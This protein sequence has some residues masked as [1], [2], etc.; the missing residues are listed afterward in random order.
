MTMTRRLGLFVLTLCLVAASAQAQRARVTGTVVD[1]DGRPARRATVL[2]VDQTAI[3]GRAV[4]DSQGR[5][6]VADLAAGRYELRA[7]MEGFA[8]PPVT[9]ALSPDDSQTVTLALQV[10]AVSESVVVTAAGRELP[11]SRVTDS[12][13][14][15]TADDIAARQ[16]ETVADALRFTV[17]GLGV[18]ST[19]GR[20][21]QTALFTRGGESDFTLVMID[22]VR[23]NGFGG[24]FDFAH[25]PV[26]DIER[27]EVV[28]GP[29][30]AVYGS[31]AIGG[32][33]QIITKQGGPARV[34]GIIEG[35][36]FGTSRVSVNT[37][38]T[39]GPVA[40]GAAFEQLDTDGQR[41][42][43]S[44]AGETVS[45][46]DYSR[47]DV[48]LHGQW[49]G[50][51][52][53]TVRSVFRYGTNERGF[54]GP[55]GSNPGGTYAGIDTLARGT[56]DNRLVSVGVSQR[57]GTRVDQ[58]VELSHTQT[59]SLFNGPFGESVS[60]A[61]RL[62]FRAR[63]N[64]TLSDN[65]VATGGFDIQQEQ[66]GST[67][68]T[69]A[70]FIETPVDRRMLGFFGELRFDPTSRLSVTA[71]IRGDRITREGLPGDGFARPTFGDETEVAANPKV[72]LGWYL[73]PTETTPDWT[74]LRVSAA[75]GIR[76]PS[77]F[78]IA[79]TDNPALKSER[80][81][82]VDV[83]VEQA[84]AGGRVLVEATA[85]FNRYD[86]LIVSVGQS[87]QNAS[88]FRT[89]NL[90]NSQARGLEFA[91]TGRTPQGF[92]A[93]A[94]YTWLHT[95]ILAVDS[96]ESEAP[97]G[98]SI[99]DA[100][101]RRPRHQGSVELSF[102]QPVFSVFTSIGTRS[103]TLDVDPSF[104]SCGGFFDNPGYAVVNLGG[105]VHAW[106]GV[107][108]TARVQNLLDRRYEEAF[109][110][111]TLGRSVMAGIRVR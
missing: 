68:I 20:G 10:S 40:W 73:R 29:Q 2:V 26:G 93:R 28:R 44:Q 86:D 78:E 66:A 23:V 33:V 70:S 102:T 6:H 13:T 15:V 75:T 7:A 100:L 32:V 38:G 45:N 76:P 99:G 84:L 60:D 41:G 43:T 88:Q 111:P 56:N 92:E 103:A 57:L 69:D 16:F 36:T 14:V 18:T 97:G 17:P 65:I 4:T 107:E 49:K 94:S 106:T 91:A 67:F 59:D 96:T 1:P 48:S 51:G 101:L 80:T 62:T 50:E 95:E 9:I 64:V 82:S 37:A 109:G 90:S 25:L 61:S 74:R 85:F 83:G 81:R 98:F 24:A 63:T 5:F 8:A 54:P 108:F 55:W 110:F 31:D 34:G 105:S 87:F 52:G 3:R 72:S 58:R 12:V 22:G 21:G 77:A 30:S 35:G 19:G 104:G 27:I 39:A 11:R 79:F 42:E 47:R 53:T 71:G 46:D 89:D